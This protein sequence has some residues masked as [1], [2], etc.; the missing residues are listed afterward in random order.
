M[1]VN[2]E[3]IETEQ[4]LLTAI[5]EMDEASRESMLSLFEQQMGIGLNISSQQNL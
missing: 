1:Y 2:G 5:Q 4:Q 3:F